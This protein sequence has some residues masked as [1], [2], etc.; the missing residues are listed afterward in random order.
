[1]PK[2]SFAT[3]SSTF[4]VA[5]TVCFVT[6]CSSPQTKAAISIKLRIPCSAILHLR[7]QIELFLYRRGN[8]GVFHEE[9]CCIRHV[10][11]R[12][13]RSCKTWLPETTWVKHIR[14]FWSGLGCANC[15]C[16]LISIQVIWRKG[17]ARGSTS[18]S[19]K[20]PSALITFGV[21][22]VL[23]AL[24]CNYLKRKIWRTTSRCARLF[25]SD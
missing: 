10:W 9:I 14:W 19:S 3:W 15:R 11:G 17:N 5:V 20:K 6:S 22:V 25:K 8:V 4:C 24:L 7:L 2:P 23:A 18:C 12:D 21:W 13:I 16:K 1:M